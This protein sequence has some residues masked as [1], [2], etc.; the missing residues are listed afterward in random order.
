MELE[1]EVER[2]SKDPVIPESKADHELDVLKDKRKSYS[3]ETKLAATQAYHKCQTVQDKIWHKTFNASWMVAKRNQDSYS[4]VVLGV[5][6][7]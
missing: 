6:R 7:K 3:R 1:A 5:P 2:V 4:T